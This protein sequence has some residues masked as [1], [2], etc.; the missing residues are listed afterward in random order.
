MYEGPNSTDIAKYIPIMM[1]AI[2]IA[3]PVIIV[4]IN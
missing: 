2:Y 3:Y 1:M 4:I